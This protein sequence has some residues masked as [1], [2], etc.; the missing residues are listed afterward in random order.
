MITNVTMD[1]VQELQSLKD[2]MAQLLECASHL[3]NSSSPNWIATME[4]ALSHDHQWIG[5]NY[6][7]TFQDTIDAMKNEIQDEESFE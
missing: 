3:L 4:M 2:E 6:D 7:V 1:D 5:G